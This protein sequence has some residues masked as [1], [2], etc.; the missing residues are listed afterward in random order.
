M[1][2]VIT[3]VEKVTTPI[4]LILFLRVSLLPV[5]EKWFHGG[6]VKEL[7]YY[8]YSLLSGHGCR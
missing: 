2:Y 4:S 3:E 6:R 5:C 8:S 7:R 1:V